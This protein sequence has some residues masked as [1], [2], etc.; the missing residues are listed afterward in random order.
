MKGLFPMKMYT[1][2]LF[3]REL[4]GALSIRREEETS[5]LYKVIPGNSRKRLT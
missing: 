1:G 5:L 3:A 2:E 4:E